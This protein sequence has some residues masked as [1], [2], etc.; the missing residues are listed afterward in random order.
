VNSPEILKRLVRRFG[1]LAVLT[2]LGAIAGGIYSSLV[3]PT[4]QAQAY[5]VAS[6]EAGEGPAALNFAQ[7]YGRIATKGPVADKAATKLGTTKGLDQVTASTSPDTPVIEITATGTDAKQTAAVANAVA[8]SLVEFGATR[9]TETRVT[10]TVLAA[11][12]VPGSPSS[13]KPP[14]E[15]AVGAAGGLLIGGLAV[16][17]GVGRVKQQVEVA[18]ERYQVAQ[19]VQP[20]QL[21]Q[22]AVQQPTMQAL[23]VSYSADGQP[24]FEPQPN[25]DRQPDTDQKIVGRAV[26]IY[27]QEDPR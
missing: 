8:Q 17:A 16:L 4:Y 22:P 13:P 5:V 26:V 27:Q 2:L 20:Q 11:A 18:D 24:Q 1:L 14:L 12:T 15:I 10:L 9:K 25:F 23:T 6:A 19:I 7:A 3:T 21:G